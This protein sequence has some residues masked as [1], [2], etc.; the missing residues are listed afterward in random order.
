MLRLFAALLFFSS[1]SM[2]I[3]KNGGD[4]SYVYDAKKD[5]SKNDLAQ[6]APKVVASSF[7]SPLKGKLENLFRQGQR[8]LK[9]IGILIF[10]T[11]IQPTREGLS[12]GNLVYMSEQGKQLMT[13]NFLHLWE[14]SQSLLAPELN[15]IPTLQIIKS[16]KFHEYGFEEE[17]FIKSRR[18]TLSV[19]DIFYI[20]A[21][22]KTTTSTIVNPRGMRDMSFMLVPA[23][24]LMGGPKWSE[25]NKHFLND[26]AKE[27]NLD[28]VVIVMSDIFWTAGHKD[29]FKDDYVQEEA[30]IKIRASTLIPLSQYH[31]RLENIGDHEKP[32]VTLCYRSYESEIK[33]PISISVPE[34]MKNFDTIEHELITPVMK[35]YKDVSQMTLIRIADDLKKTW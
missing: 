31:E 32:G 18:N 6:M 35:T 10:E 13:E 26:V 7:R 29:K 16:K 2:G 20:A 1:C 14:M 24:D 11:Q 8:P 12:R 27:L 30:T 25:H 34:K 3:I 22:K 28:A 33:I 9:R 5:Y 19:D 23:Y 4:K 17:D 21:G 15:Y